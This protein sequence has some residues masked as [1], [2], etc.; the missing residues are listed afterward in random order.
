[1]TKSG[2]LM[3]RISREI[4]AWC[5][6][7]ALLLSSVC[8]VQAAHRDVTLEQ[9]QAAMQGILDWKKGT[10]DAG[11]GDLLSS[12]LLSSA[13]TSAADWYAFG[14]GRCGFEEDRFSYLSVLKQEVQKRYASSQRLDARKATEWHRIALTVLALGGDP[15]VMGTGESPIN[16]IQDGTY[17]RGKTVSLGTQGINGY[18]WGLITLD[19]LHYAVPDDASD[20][21]GSILTEI[22]SSQLPDGSWSLDGETPDV[23]TT[24]MALQALAPYYN[25]EALYSF[26]RRS[27]QSSRSGTVRAAADQAVDFLS[28]AQQPDGDFSAWGVL[29]LES[30]AQVMT[31]LCSLGIDPVN[32]SRF[33]KKGNS[34]LDGLLKYRCA[35]GGFAHSFESD[36][37]NPSAAA[38]Q[39]NSM[40]GEQ[41]LYALC[42]LYRYRTGLRSLYDFRAEMSSDVREQIAALES[43]ISRL[44]ENPEE[45]GRDQVQTLF[46]QYLQIPG[47]ERSYV[48][49]YS[50][51]AEA[52]QAL[53]IENTSGD[54]ACYLEEN[55]S[56][57][58]AVVRIFSGQ[59]AA[60]GLLFNA[61][62]L[63]ACHALPAVMTTEYAAEV[64]RLYEKLCQAE[65]AADYEEVRAGLLAK[66]EAIESIEAEIESINREISTRLYPFDQLTEQD[67]DLIESLV[68]RVEALS[69]Y[70]Q[71]RVLAFEDLLQA[72]A[73]LDSSF[74]SIWMGVTAAVLVLL[75]AG[76][77]IRRRQKRRVRRRAE[78]MAEENEDW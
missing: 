34:V 5:L 16:L 53:G 56:G 47:N 3:G 46:E 44:P 45:A 74:R 76:L 37:A 33:L 43:G 71:T 27:D 70:D 25:S 49:G 38:G 39:S 22:L 7:L 32:D 18:L 8:T 75:C 26:R 6:C 72:K 73:R 48:R 50:R 13:G 10:C 78:Q 24:A 11:S 20:T 55:T 29:S 42:A 58:G 54:I 17:D 64:T 19:A 68:R 1:M 51:L 63:D 59:N 28:R 2:S 62:D 65:N 69:P 40:A 9:L 66:K 12:G 57:S 61:D 35:D 52:M 36:S 21:R 41:A 14:V 15:T 77:L 23:D 4:W 30:T 31:A 60:S 67:R